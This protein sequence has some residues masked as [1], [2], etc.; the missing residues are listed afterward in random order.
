MKGDSDNMKNFII[1]V[2]DVSRKA[3][4]FDTPTVRA[5]LAA[6]PFASTANVWG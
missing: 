4:V 6:L 3:E 1:S 5:I 2:E